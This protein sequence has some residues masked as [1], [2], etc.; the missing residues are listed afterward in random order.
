M[1]GFLI[2]TASAR[3]TVQCSVS[4]Y[5]T[6]G[7]LPQQIATGFSTVSSGSVRPSSPQSDQTDSR[8]D[9]NQAIQANLSE[10]IIRC[11]M[12]KGSTFPWISWKF[13]GWERVEKGKNSVRH[14]PKGMDRWWSLRTAIH[15][16]R[17]YKL[18]IRKVHRLTVCVCYLPW[19]LRITRDV[20]VLSRAHASCATMVR[21][22]LVKNT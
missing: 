20:H 22:C 8:Q 16:H 3:Q 5:Y 11:E 17:W 1:K 12:P 6:S 19:I 7:N 2:N 18:I 10:R 14:T 15:E 4:S 21:L 13:V 9:K